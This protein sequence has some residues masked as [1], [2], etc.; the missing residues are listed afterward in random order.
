MLNSTFT[1]RSHVVTRSYLFQIGSRVTGYRHSWHTLSLSVS[2]S[3][4]SHWVLALLQGVI[5]GGTKSAK[6][7]QHRMRVEGESRVPASS[8]HL[9]TAHSTEAL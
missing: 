1:T 6:E 3:H 2:V 4:T 7:A 8:F 5:E 9:G